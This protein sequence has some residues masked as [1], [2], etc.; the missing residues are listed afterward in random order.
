MAV[1]VKVLAASATV[2]FCLSAASAAFASCG[3]PSGGG[4]AGGSAHAPSSGAGHVSSGSSS[5]HV[6]SGGGGCASDMTN[7]TSFRAF[8]NG[9][10]PRLP[11]GAGH[12]PIRH[13]NFT[14][15]AA[16]TAVSTANTHTNLK[17]SH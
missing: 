6:Y 7:R 14:K 5:P 8:V 3:I 4:G 9:G 16:P 13:A 10:A 2:F 12:G 11:V 15:T 17:K 1:Q